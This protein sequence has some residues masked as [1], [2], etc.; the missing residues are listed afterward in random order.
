MY[1][2]IYLKKLYLKISPL[3]GTYEYWF[4]EKQLP[5]RP[6]IDGLKRCGL[7]LLLLSLN[8]NSI[9]YTYNI[10]NDHCGTASVESS[11]RRIQN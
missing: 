6:P 7:C 11:P 9:T 3:V 1:H 5:I 10:T 4:S 2:K 8:Q